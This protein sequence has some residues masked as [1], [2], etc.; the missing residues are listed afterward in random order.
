MGVQVSP[1]LV[2]PSASLGGGVGGETKFLGGVVSVGRGRSRCVGARVPLE[3]GLLVVTETYVGGLVSS[4]SGPHRGAAWRIMSRAHVRRR[5][6]GEA[7]VEHRAG[8]RRAA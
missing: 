5:P 7:R 1:L 8:S 4:A 6:R 2:W 3:E